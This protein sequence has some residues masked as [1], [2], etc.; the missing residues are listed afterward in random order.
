MS[1]DRSAGSQPARLDRSQ[2]PGA[3]G[4]RGSV[5]DLEYRNELRGVLGRF[6]TGI[7]VVTA[8]SAIGPHGM[9]ANSFT[10]VSLAPPLVLV[11]VMRDASMHQAILDSDSFGVSMLSTRHESL[12]TYFANRGRPRDEH[13]FDLVDWV[14]GRHTGVPIVTQTLAW[15]ECGLSAVYD[16]GDHSIFLGSVLDVGRG[17]DDDALLFFGG[18]YR[19]LESEL[20][21]ESGADRR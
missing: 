19:R 4:P 21:S 7:T 20:A 14:P 15:I 16:G 12:A 10:S 18:N 2:S 3:V 6:A 13:E 5:H 9:T 1:A 17:D 11:C 8:N